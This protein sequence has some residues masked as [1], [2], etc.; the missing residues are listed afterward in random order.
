MTRIRRTELR[1]LRMRDPRI[2]RKEALKI[3][4]VQERISRADALTCRVN[5]NFDGF[6]SVYMHMSFFGSNGCHRHSKDEPMREPEL[7]ELS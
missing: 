6:C 4:R 5:L 7:Q 1:L 3:I 2:E